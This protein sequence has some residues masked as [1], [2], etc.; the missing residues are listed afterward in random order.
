[1]NKRLCTLLGALLLTGV[2]GVTG[3]QSTDR[4]Q[5]SVEVPSEV[6]VEDSAEQTVLTGKDNTVTVRCESGSGNG[7][8]LAQTEG[9]CVIVTAG[10]VVQ[11]LEGKSGQE[12]AVEIAGTQ[13]TAGKLYVSDTFDVAFVEV[14]ADVL[15][16]P[17]AEK[18]SVKLTEEGFTNLKEGDTLCVYSYLQGELTDTYITVNSPWIYIEDFGYH[19]IWASA[20]DAKGGM[21]GSGAFD[22]DGHLVGILCGGNENEVAILPMNII[23]GELKNSSI[24]ISFE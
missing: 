23:L 8:L 5:D 4:L 9:T 12:L 13:A 18:Q 3:C 19:M 6:L 20:T 1:M 15:A 22:Q 2:C 7:V 11:G 10:H 17:L 14:P 21:S 24:D 16:E